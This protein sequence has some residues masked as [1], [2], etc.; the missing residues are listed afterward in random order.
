MR[1]P[2]IKLPR[3]VDMVIGHELCIRRR[4]SKPMTIAVETAENFTYYCKGIQGKTGFVI[5][6]SLALKK[7]PID[8][9]LVN[10]LQTIKGKNVANYIIQWGSVNGD[11]SA[12]SG[13]VNVDKSIRPINPGTVII[14]GY[15]DRPDESK[16]KPAISVT[17]YFHPQNALPI[18]PEITLSDRE[19]T[20]MFVFAK[21]TGT[22]QAVALSRLNA[23]YEEIFALLNK[24]AIRHARGGYEM[25]LI[26]MSAAAEKPGVDRW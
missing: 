22:E 7:A 12:G 13:I 5:D 19:R 1:Y 15:A 3:A 9:H 2:I 18:I 25:T 23:T 17:A 4:Y 6:I 21:L 14:K 24:Q 16:N 10:R 11:L 26:G 20:L 8:P